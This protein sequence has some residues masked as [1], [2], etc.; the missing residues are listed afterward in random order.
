M[1]GIG[2]SG[3][4]A[5]ARSLRVFNVELGCNLTPPEANVNEKGF[6]ENEDVLA[7]NRAMLNFIDSDWDKVPIP[8]DADDL[9][10]LL[11]SEFFQRACALINR[12][13]MSGDIFGFKDGRTTK[14]IPFWEKVF[15]ETDC[16]VFYL[17]AF[18][19]PMGVAESYNKY[20]GIS[21]KQIYSLWAGYLITSLIHSQ[22]YKR[23]LVNYDRLLEQPEQELNHISNKLLLEIRSDELSAY[24]SEFLDTKLRHH[25]YNLDD[26]ECEKAVPQLAKDMY[27]SL[28][29]LCKEETIFDSFILRTLVSRWSLKWREL[30]AS[31]AHRTP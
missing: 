30:E 31:M 25:I 18:R 1:L 5:I 20:I 13:S 12:K 27:A 9:Q 21:R 10:R 3:T 23:A 24:M 16:E 7:L 28:V 29:R 2:R 19:N 8:I 17:I 6:W 15:I 11:K 4:S 26:L 22:G 14:L